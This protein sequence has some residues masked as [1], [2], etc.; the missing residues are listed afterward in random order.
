MRTQSWS[1]ECVSARN[2]IVDQAWNAAMILR[3]CYWSTGRQDV[4]RQI[5]ITAKHLKEVCPL[6]RTSHVAMIFVSDY[7][8][9]LPCHCREGCSRLISQDL[10]CKPVWSFKCGTNAL[11]AGIHHVVSILFYS[12]IGGLILKGPSCNWNDKTPNVVLRG[13]ASTRTGLQIVCELENS[14]PAYIAVCRS[15]DQ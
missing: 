14:L 5:A 11:F 4:H 8:D 7:A 1:R 3:T 10:R 12:T 15:R 13:N 9:F 6:S 2:P